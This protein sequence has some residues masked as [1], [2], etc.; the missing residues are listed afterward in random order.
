MKTNWAWS[1]KTEA[2]RIAFTCA[3]IANGFYNQ[4]GYTILPAST[5]TSTPNTTIFLP[6]LNYT[7]IPRFWETVAQVDF[8][9]TKPLKYQTIDPLLKPIISRLI[10]A[11]TL[12]DP[13][14]PTRSIW[15]KHS[16]QLLA[17]LCNL[18]NIKQSEIKQ[19][20]IHPTS[21]GS[22]ASFDPVPN[23]HNVHIKIELRLDQ[24]I[25]TLLSAIALSLLTPSLTSKHNATWKQI[26][27]L[28]D[29]LVTDS[30]LS[31]LIE[32]LEPTVSQSDTKNL[33]HK[34]ARVS[35]LEVSK[36]FLTR[37]GAPSGNNEQ[38]AQLQDKIL[39]KNKP[40]LYLT[41]REKNILYTLI[42][43]RPNTVSLEE[44]GDIIF[45][46]PDDYSIATINKVIQHLRDKLEKNSIPASMI[47][48][49]YGQ[50]YALR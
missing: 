39:Y 18:I 6:D 17:K 26:K 46:T 37:I 38:L 9:Q 22:N 13:P 10:L 16:D 14:H 34:L 21:Y 50:G 1:Y 25:K 4:Q 31:K 48:T 30:P 19:L 8:K 44:I 3:N 12:V 40:I 47:K 20:T 35:T 45:P 36:L 27:F 33:S 7:T 29:W 43:S 11:N 42:K 49:I 15:N 5:P 2:S 23:L 32:K 28:T 41:A 24:G